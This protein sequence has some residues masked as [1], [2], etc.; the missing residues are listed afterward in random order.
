M[1][2]E[3]VISNMLWRFMERIGAQGVSFFVTIILARILEPSAF[4]T[5]ALV[6]VFI[7]ILE[8]FVDSGLGTALV[9]KKDADELDFTT[10]LCFNIFACL[11][12]YCLLFFLAPAIASFYNLPDMI[13]LIRVLSIT[14]IISGAKN[15]LWAYVSRNL[16]F[17]KFFLNIMWDYRSGH[18][19]D[20]DGIQ[21]IWCLGFSCTKLIEQFYRYSFSMGLGRLEAHKELFFIQIERIV[22]IW[23]KVVDI[24][25]S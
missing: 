22:F 13:P 18:S 3:K 17:K 6:M 21:R 10:V 11:L 8:V 23:I 25:T 1:K 4:G 2:R 14:V 12:V 19:G 24:W 9:Q 15:V 16:L 5:I 20:M 7:S